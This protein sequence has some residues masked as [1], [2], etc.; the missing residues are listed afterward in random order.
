[1][2]RR[3]CLCTNSNGQYSDRFLKFTNKHAFLF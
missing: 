1:V 3:I 2:L